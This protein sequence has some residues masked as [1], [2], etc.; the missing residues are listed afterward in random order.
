MIPATQLPLAQRL[1]ETVKVWIT[2]PIADSA[3]DPDGQIERARQTLCTLAFRERDEDT[4]ITPETDR[5]KDPR[6]M[7]KI[8]DQGRIGKGTPIRALQVSFT[9]RGNAAAAM[10][11]AD[12]FHSLCG[13]VEK[14][15]DSFSLQIANTTPPQTYLMR[16]WSSDQWQLATMLAVREP[17]IQF[18]IEGDIRKQTYQLKV[19]AVGL[20]F[21]V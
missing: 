20:E 21:T 16:A 14:L 1:M 9:I 19:R 5:A 3:F 2:T 11:Q 10:G 13:A 4:T 8:D 15:I 17:G 7:C 12:P 18:S 6:F